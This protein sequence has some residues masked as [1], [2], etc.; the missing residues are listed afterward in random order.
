MADWRRDARQVRGN[1]REGQVT[2]A[3]DR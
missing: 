1:S 3:H 2:V